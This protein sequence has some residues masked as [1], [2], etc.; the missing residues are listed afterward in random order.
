MKKVTLDAVINRQQKKDPEF[1]EEYQK[2]LLRNEIAKIVVK[3]RNN[4]HLTQTELAEKAGTTQPVIAR[5]ESGA[6]SRVPSLN[7]L[8][9]IAE[10]SH[11][12][13]HVSFELMDSRK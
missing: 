10:A 2:E 3:L 8:A 12:K 1:A 7:L 9:R 13:L 6:D 4:V 5:L 11:A